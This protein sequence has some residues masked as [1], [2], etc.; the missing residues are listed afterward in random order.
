MVA[1]VTGA[2]TSSDDHYTVP[3]ANDDVL[4]M[5]QTAAATNSLAT[6]PPALPESPKRILVITYYIDNT[7]NPPRLMRQ[8]SGHT[9]MPVAE[10]VVYLK[11][12]YDLFNA[13]H[14][15]PAVNQPT[16]LGGATASRT[17]P[18]PDHQDQHSEHGDG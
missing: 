1:E 15:T 16:G 6:P 9:P 7:L 10:N 18:Q 11:F 17:S 8:V 5:N 13:H 4:H 3:F 14:Q 2:V 12:S